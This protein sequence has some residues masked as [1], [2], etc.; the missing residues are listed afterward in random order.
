M[1]EAR[2]SP[3]TQVRHTAMHAAPG[4][5]GCTHIQPHMARYT[6]E[7]APLPWCTSLRSR[8][9]GMHARLRTSNTRLASLEPSVPVS[10]QLGLEGSSYHQRSGSGCSCSASCGARPG[11]GGGSSGGR[12]QRGQAGGRVRTATLAYDVHAR[13][14]QAWMREL[15][16]GGGGQTAIARCLV[17]RRG[18]RPDPAEWPQLQAR[19]VATRR[20]HWHTL[21]AKGTATRI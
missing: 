18:G 20:W 11:R 9:G 4:H 10:A 3:P 7:H 16:E 19:R 8:R 12:Q 15:C 2:R 21:R 17:R 1:G 13:Q 5:R 14:V 6:H